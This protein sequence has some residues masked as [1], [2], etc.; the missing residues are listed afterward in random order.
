MIDAGA[1]PERF[2]GGITGIDASE[3]SQFVSAMLMPAPLWRDGLTLKVSG[4]A[5]RPFIAMTLD[6]MRAWGARSA[7]D[8]DTITVPG[9]QSYR[10][11]RFVVEPD[12]SSASYFAAAAALLGGTV[13]LEGIR[14]SSVQG[15]ARFMDVLEQMGA[16]VTWSDRGVEVAGTGRLRG[17]DL[18]MNAMPDMVATLAAI[19]PFASSPTR[20][21]GVAF[22]RHHESDRIAALA[23]ELRK[24]R[25][26]GRRIRRRTRDPAV[27]HPRRE[28]RDLR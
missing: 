25:R 16:R 24:T 15:D 17:V 18:A 7:H 11:Q 3:S 2:S 12:A 28:R 26:Y 27:K 9:G 20:I 14:K 5:A 10:A 19:A 23:T 4:D 13:T 6:L 22:I 8:G 21:R 1:A